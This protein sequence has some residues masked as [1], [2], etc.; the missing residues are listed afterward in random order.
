MGED[1]FGRNPFPKQCSNS[2]SVLVRIKPIDRCLNLEGY[3]L[4]SQFVSTTSYKDWQHTETFDA[5]KL[6]LS[7]IFIYCFEAFLDCKLLYLL[8]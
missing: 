8:R 1:K 3:K 6:V 7:V 4:I 5:G 2:Y